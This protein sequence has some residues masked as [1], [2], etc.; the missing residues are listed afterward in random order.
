MEAMDRDQLA[1]GYERDAHEVEHEHELR[2]VELHHAHAIGGH[3]T[4]AVPPIDAG[5]LSQS[6]EHGAPIG[7]GDDKASAVDAINQNLEQQRT[8]QWNAAEKARLKQRKA[9]IKE[10]QHGAH[11]TA[12][13]LVHILQTQGAQTVL[14]DLDKRRPGEG[15]H[16]LKQAGMW[17]T[18]VAGLPVG[19]LTGPTARALDRL[20]QD[21][22]FGLADAEAL[23]PKRFTHSTEDIKG[24]NGAAWNMN[25]LQVLWRTLARLPGE[26]VSRDV[27]ISAFEAIAGGGGM[28]DGGVDIGQDQGGDNEYLSHTVLHEVGHAVMAEIN[29]QI[30][31]WLYNDIQFQP[32][33]FEQFVTDLG[34]YGSVDATHQ[35]TVLAM[36]E[37]YTGT[38]S[39]GP[40]R[41][42]VDAGQPA[43]AAAAWQQMPGATRNACVQSKQNWYSNFEHFQQV[44]G[45][46]YFLNHWYHSA[47]KL[48]APAI[49]G[50]IATNDRYSAMSEN[51]FFANCYAEYFHDPRGVSNHKYWGGRLPANIQSFF[52]DVV[53]SRQPYQTWKTKKQAPARPPKQ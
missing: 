6:V 25:N 13:E 29:S 45:T 53:L 48:G 39:W 24:T 42:T 16:L 40:T 43:D 50:I 35:P 22:V 38:S 7:D 17:P 41:K 52:H 23:F 49:A 8:N 36:I 5:A 47:Y 10:R 31:P 4:S 1:S 44:G 18:L 26:D 2:E 46:R 33:S 12:P 20:V 32:I 27:A 21:N 28:Y 11:W 9:R 34:G 37:S 51:E 3:A 30:T 14:V 15:V 19:H